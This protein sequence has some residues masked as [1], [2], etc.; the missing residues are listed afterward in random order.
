MGR[1]PNQAIRHFFERGPKLNDNSNRYQQT[2]R[3]CGE[4][5]EKGRQEALIAHVAKSCRGVNSQERERFLAEVSAKKQAAKTK[6]T[7]ISSELPHALPELSGLEALAE[8]SRHHG[9]QSLQNDLI[10]Q[11][12]DFMG[13]SDVNNQNLLA[14]ASNTLPF[15]TTSAS[16]SLLIPT[17]VR[18]DVEHSDELRIAALRALVPPRT[19]YLER[20]IDNDDALVDYSHGEA[21]IIGVNYSR[22]GPAHVI[23]SAGDSPGAADDLVDYGHGQAPIVDEHYSR[24]H[25]SP[26]SKDK[27]TESTHRTLDPLLSGTQDS[28]SCDDHDHMKL[29]AGYVADGDIHT[30]HDMDLPV[31]SMPPASGIDAPAFQTQHV[32]DA[33]AQFQIWHPGGKTPAVPKKVRGAFALDRRAA[34]KEVRKKGAC[35]RCRMLK[36]ACDSDDPCKECA[37]LEN[38]RMWKGQ[39][40]RIRL[41]QIFNVFSSTLFMNIAHKTT[42]QLRRTTTFTNLPGRLE[43]SYF[44]NDSLFMTFAGLRASN[45]DEGQSRDIIDNDDEGVG[46]GSTFENKIHHYGHRALSTHFDTVDGHMMFTNMSHFMSHAIRQ[47]MV[48]QNCVLIARALDLWICVT[49]LTKPRQDLI[50]THEPHLP[51]SNLPVDLAH[52]A[53]QRSTG[54]HYI[55][56]QLRRKL[57][58]ACDTHFKAIM[59]ELE[60]SLIQRRQADN[61]ET[62]L[63]TTILLRCVEMVSYMYKGYDHLVDASSNGTRKDELYGADAWPLENS[64][65]HYWQQGERFSDLLSSMLRLRKV[66]PE[67]TVRGGKIKV[68]DEN[69]VVRDWFE[70]IDVEADSLQRARDNPYDAID[71]NA[72]EFRWMGKLLET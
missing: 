28:Q 61:F 11:S 60:K 14:R 44:P 9:Q 12:S 46:I 70:A 37:K 32:F 48:M 36:K 30:D 68:Q 16:N 5:F 72:W 58:R 29:V 55:Y 31:S 42:E 50:A 18:Q 39:C 67:Y 63:G 43:I 52:N 33:Q 25:K 17:T 57:E 8:V 53:T 34:V 3:R 38:A 24:H 6:T 19:N 62:F 47:A 23:D 13:R 10:A 56:I 35:L 7:I 69:E 4:K 45:D 40:L 71:E 22:H 20:T 41:S 64:P 15:H 1:K 26:S 59:T 27:S 2:C 51:P 65:N 66:L 54:T 21:P 49:F